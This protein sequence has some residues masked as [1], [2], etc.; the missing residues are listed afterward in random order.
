VTRH[1]RCIARPLRLRERG[2]SLIELMVAV[3]VGLLGVL[4]IMSVFVSSEAQKRATM[5]GADASENALIALVT[6]ERDLR[7]AGLGLV[8]LDCTT[9]QAHN[10]KSS[11]TEIS[12]EPW[13][14]E[15][16]RE[17]TSDKVAILY[18]VSALG[19]VPVLLAAP[20]PQSI[21]TLTVTN[22]DGVVAGD[23]ILVSEG[24]KPC[25]LLQASGPAVES[26]ANWIIPHDAGEKFPFNSAANFFAGDIAAGFSTGAKVT[27]MGA[28]IR[29]E[30][31]VQ[32]DKLMMQDMNQPV[33]SGTN[34]A[35]LVEGVVAMRA[36][37]GVDT[38]GDG[39]L[40][41]Y[42]DTL[43]ADTRR[44]VAV[45]VAVVARGGQLEKTAVS[46]EKLVL[47]TGGTVADG[48]AVALDA[49]Q[50]Q[51]RYKVYKTIVPLRNVIWGNNP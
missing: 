41:S 43:P 9:T 10:E 8:G 49:T 26:G 25:A 21:S 47:W 44:V 28:M 15:I 12:F 14:V 34:P 29:R 39:Y 33:V 36:R 32:D 31:F 13:P 6:M 50:Q 46:P 27:N 3:V 45:Q 1:P 23:L 48:G 5:G 38:S 22:G 51:Y 24:A 2:F 16:T 19:N 40:D 35:A 30:Y 42:E 17:S 4:A 7:M 11:P 20:L 18:S 37:Y